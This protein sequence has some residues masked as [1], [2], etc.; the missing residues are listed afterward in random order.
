MV[1]LLRITDQ[2]VEYESDP[3]RTIVNRFNE[4]AYSM[5]KPVELYNFRIKLFALCLSLLLTGLCLSTVVF[6]DSSRPCADEIEKFCKDI[7]PGGGKMLSCLQEHEKDLSDTCRK[8]L[9]ESKRK[10]RQTK[11]ACGADVEKFCK[12]I[13][14]G[15]GRIMKCLRGHESELSPDC[16]QALQKAGRRKR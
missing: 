6:A 5:R 13:Q 12:D 16:R 4:R 14:P 2:E 8:K 9:L 7:Q 15:G 11:E 3:C 10:A 1:Y